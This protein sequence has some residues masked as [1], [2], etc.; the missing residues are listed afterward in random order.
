MTSN[1]LCVVGYELGH[2]PELFQ[3]TRRA[4]YDYQKT[5][6]MP[7]LQASGQESLAGSTSHWKS[8]YK[9]VNDDQLSK[10]LTKSERPV[11]SYPRQA[12]SS[13]RSYFSTEYQ[14]SL[15]T[16]GHNPRNKLPTDA[17]KT[18][19]EN[20]ELTAG[21][22]KTTSHIPGYNGFIP[23]TDFNPLAVKQANELD[24]R[25]TIIKQNIIENYQVKLPGYQGHKPMNGCN[26]KG[27]I[28][29]NCLATMGEKFS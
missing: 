8:N 20:H 13:K 28:R 12:Y 6:T 29:P 16:Y 14:K 15:G 25:D 23:K 18:L 11:W 2:K 1:I 17:T 7:T 10:P 4:Q 9:A 21:T 3:Y 26:E 5:G 27:D 19:N 22:T 24:A